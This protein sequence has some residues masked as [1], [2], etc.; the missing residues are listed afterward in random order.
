[1]IGLDY[2]EWYLS[3]W[4]WGQRTIK[5]ISSGQLNWWILG[6]IMGMNENKPWVDSE[7]RREERVW[8]IRCRM[9]PESIKGG[10]SWKTITDDQYRNITAQRT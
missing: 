10:D 2:L 3:G 8:W 7:H 9:S 1:M 6:S 4:L 5:D